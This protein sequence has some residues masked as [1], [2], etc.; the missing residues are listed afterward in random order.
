MTVA[1]QCSSFEAADLREPF[2][3]LQSDPVPLD[4]E[5]ADA[6]RLE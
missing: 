1:V 4:V 3:I 6:Q 5:Y 2:D